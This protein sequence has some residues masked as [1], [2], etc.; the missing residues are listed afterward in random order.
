MSSRH[1]KRLNNLNEDNESSDSSPKLSAT[2][3]QDVV[4]NEQE[5]RKIN[6]KNKK[7]RNNRRKKRSNNKTIS[8]TSSTNPSPNVET[9]SISSEKTSFLKINH[10]NLNYMAEDAK[11]LSN[12]SALNKQKLNTLKFSIVPFR[13]DWDFVKLKGISMKMN[14]KTNSGSYWKFVYDTA[15]CDLTHE[16]Y[17][18]CQFHDE[19][20]LMRLMNQNPHH[21]ESLFRYGFLLRI[22]DDDPNVYIE[23]IERALYIFEK[24]RHINFNFYDPMFHLSYTVYENRTFLMCL[25]VH[26]LNLED[27]CCYIAC[28]EY[29]KLLLCLDPSDPLG[30]LCFFDFFCIKSKAYESFLE[31]YESNQR[32]DLKSMPNMRF[33]YALANYILKNDE[34][35]SLAIQSALIDFPD[36]FSLAAKI[37][38]ISVPKDIAS[39]PFFTNKENCAIVTSSILGLYVGKM[40]FLLRNAEVFACYFIRFLIFSRPTPEGVCKDMMSM[41]ICLNRK[42]EKYSDSNIDREMSNLS[43]NILINDPFPPLKSSNMFVRPIS[44]SANMNQPNAD[45]LVEFVYRITQNIYIYM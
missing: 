28:L 3:G 15:Y 16:F 8:T 35:G 13:A 36:I 27:K 21:V 41:K 37:S 26:I 6:S 9:V 24:S 25:F 23:L 20:S 39:H 2:E 40:K 11:L 14:S 31:F 44:L 12:F 18:L 19:E 1:I 34:L 17:D 43:M 4:K 42:F 38:S 5:I 29:C 30:V 32:Y 10:K 33:S 45:P 22:K 7:K